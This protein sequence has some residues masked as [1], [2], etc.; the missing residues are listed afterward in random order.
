[1][2]VSVRPRRYPGVVV[3]AD[4]DGAVG[5]GVAGG[6][7]VGTAVR[8]VVAIAA[9]QRVVAGVAD[10][11]SFPPCRRWCRTGAAVQ[12]IGAVVAGDAVAPE[13][14]TAFSIDVKVVV[15]AKPSAVNA[16]SIVARAGLVYITDVCCRRH[17]EFR[18]RRRGC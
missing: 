17:R 9:I 10:D 16:Q 5:I 1:M 8:A 14:P 18:P 3:R 11:L 6:V 13:E 4:G 2:R 12:H 15:L 7:A